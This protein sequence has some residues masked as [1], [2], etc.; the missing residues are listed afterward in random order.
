MMHPLRWQTT[1]VRKRCLAQRSGISAV[2][3]DLNLC[4][5]VRQ[6]ECIWSE[7]IHAK[8]TRFSYKTKI[9]GAFPHFRLLAA[10]CVLKWCKDRRI[11]GLQDRRVW[12]R[13]LC[14]WKKCWWNDWWSNISRVFKFINCASGWSWSRI[15]CELAVEKGIVAG[16]T[17]QESYGNQY[18]GSGSNSNPMIQIFRSQTRAFTQSALL[19]S[20]VDYAVEPSQIR[21]P[22]GNSKPPLMRF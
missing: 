11:R 17:L 4:V 20:C 15:W 3:S 2:P 6:W 21:T 9:A 5:K 13:I 18:N 8:K 7:A 19:T 1:W 14:C 22:G 12:F 10:W 16:G